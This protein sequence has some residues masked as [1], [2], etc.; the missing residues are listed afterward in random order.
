VA[1]RE[2][3]YTSEAMRRHMLNVNIRDYLIIWQF[4]RRN[5][6]ELPRALSCRA[7]GGTW[8]NT[9][10]SIDFPSASQDLAVDISRTR[11]PWKL[12]RV[13]FPIDTA[14]FKRRQ[15]EVQPDK[16]DS[17]FEFSQAKQWEYKTLF[18]FI[19]LGIV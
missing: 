10:K 13:Y 3:A 18:G 14:L 7:S 6:F 2:S 5:S 12:I 11:V 8:K 4:S 9:R 1:F 15:W 19:L 16:D 17:G